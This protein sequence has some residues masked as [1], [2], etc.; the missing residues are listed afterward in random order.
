MAHSLLN[1]RVPRPHV[2]FL[3]SVAFCVIALCQE[4]GSKSWP[5]YRRCI[6]RPPSQLLWGQPKQHPL[7]KAKARRTLKVYDNEQEGLD[8]SQSCR[9]LRRAGVNKNGVL[10]LFLGSEHKGN[11]EK[12]N[13]PKIAT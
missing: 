1:F 6:Q 7:M 13:P 5:Q 10:Y 4:R 3:L 2:P 12:V 8:F 9:I 11:Q